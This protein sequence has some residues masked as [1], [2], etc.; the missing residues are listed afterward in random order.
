MPVPCSLPTLT[1]A[2]APEA[3]RPHLARHLTA[4]AATCD[5]NKEYMAKGEKVSLWQKIASATCVRHEI[6]YTWAAF[7]YVSPYLNLL[8]FDI[9]AAGI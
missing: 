2:G 7:H 6:I 3:S 1:F 5:A 8:A 4:A 9:A